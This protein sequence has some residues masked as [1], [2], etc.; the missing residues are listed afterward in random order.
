MHHAMDAKQTTHVCAGR[1]PFCVLH[2][3]PPP[4]TCTSPPAVYCHLTNRRTAC[5]QLPC[6][7]QVSGT[8]LRPPFPTASA[9]ACMAACDADAMCQTFTFY[10]SVTP[11]SLVS[12]RDLE[13]ATLAG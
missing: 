6:R 7:A 13:S 11:D 9:D 4:C 12:E 8:N 5:V 1:P 3:R 10:P 2:A